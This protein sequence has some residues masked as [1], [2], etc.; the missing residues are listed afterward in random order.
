MKNKSFKETVIRT[1]SGG[2]SLY[3]PGL[4]TT[5]AADITNI[6]YGQETQLKPVTH[7]GF[8]K[9]LAFDLISLRGGM[10]EQ[11]EE[12]RMYTF[13]LGIELLTFNF[14]TALGISEDFS[15]EKMLLFSGGLSF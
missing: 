3:V 8:E 6:P 7:L 4:K 12:S 14:D 5:L 15:E 10:F 11:V 9:D 13:G 1:I 2:V